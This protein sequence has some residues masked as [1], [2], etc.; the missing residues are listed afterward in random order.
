[1]AFFIALL[2][3]L[4][5]L[6]A[7]IIDSYRRA[8]NRIPGHT[9]SSQ[10]PTS[11]V[12]VIIAFRNESKN[13]TKLLDCLSAQRFP[14]HQ[15]EYILVDDFSEDDTADR[16]RAYKGKAAQQIVFISLQEEFG[17]ENNIRSHK[18]K[19]IETG[20]N[21]SR[22]SIIVTTDADC[23]F[24][25]DWL[26]TLISYFEQKQAH[27]VAAPVKISPVQGFLGIFQ[28]LDFMSLQGITGAVVSTNK[29][30]MC[31]GANLAYSKKA[32]LEVNGFEGIDDIPSGDDMLLMYK[33]YR[34]Y[35]ENVFY[36]KDP[37][38]IV[39]TEAVSSWKDFFQQR[40]RWASKATHYDD[41]RIFYVLLLVYFVNLGFLILA[42]SA[43]FKAGF[44]FFLMLL[45]IAKL[46]IE[47]P[48]VNAVS[49]FFGQQSLMKYFMLL[50]PLHIAYT[51]V[52]GWLGRFGSFEWKGRTIRNNK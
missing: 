21:K 23:C 48:F 37:A 28:A 31:N 42:I 6:Y 33:I 50:Q 39:N 18:K 2:L 30:T 43:F 47:F 19:A 52:A 26:F 17:S 45:F 12:S 32:F 27:F 11:F 9:P 25:P 38:V 41:K 7:V 24:G 5:I 16:I 51:L 1:M 10:D 14:S 46:L 4:M 13:V 15:V 36:L 40:I 35:P 20:I 8:W 49:I 34:R 29:M 22:G 3:V 44:A